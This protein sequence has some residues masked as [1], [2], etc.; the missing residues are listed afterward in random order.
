MME[1][2]ERKRK[3]A[4]TESQG[5]KDNVSILDSS[6]NDSVSLSKTP[7]KRQKLRQS[8]TNYN[9]CII[10]QKKSHVNV[11]AVEAVDTLKDVLKVKTD[12]IAMRLNRDVEKDSWLSKKQPKWH[13]NCRK[14][15]CKVPSVTQ[16]STEFKEECKHTQKTKGN[17]IVG[18]SAVC[19]DVC[20]GAKKI[21]VVCN[22][23]RYQGKYPKADMK[24]D[25]TVQKFRDQAVQFGRADI[26]G[27]IDS[28]TL[29]SSPINYHVTCMKRFRT[30]KKSPKKCK[31]KSCY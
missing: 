5:E 12:A 30:I 9:L 11:H 10:C 21:C 18:T 25:G 22:K 31:K 6:H 19:I 4:H 16:S 29:L 23:D 14:R 13:A 26:V 17:N 8:K 1:S 2:R 3:G 27:R 15:F 7:T 20:S 24:I 28:A